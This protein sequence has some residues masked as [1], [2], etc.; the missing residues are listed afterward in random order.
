MK[1][2]TR[3]VLPFLLALALCACGQ[4]AT[5]W[6]EQYD[7]GVRYLSDGNYEGAILAFTAAIEIDPKRPETYI[8]RGAAYIGRG[9]TAEN[10][11]AAQADY[12]KAIELD[13]TN[14]TAY[15]SLA[16]V[17]IRLGE[18]D[19]AIELLREVLDRTGDDTEITDK[20][21]ELEAG[22]AT[23]SY[24]HIRRSSHYNEDV[25]IGYFV[26][27]YDAQG[28]KKTITA[29]DAAGNRLDYGEYTNGER[30]GNVE[31]WTYYSEGFAE[32]RVFLCRDEI[33]ITYSA[34]GSSKELWITYEGNTEINCFGKYN[35]TQG[36]CIKEEFYD[37]DGSTYMYILHTCDEA[38]N[39]IRSDCYSYDVFT[40][41]TT[42]E[43]DDNG[44][45]IKY[46]NFNA[47]GTLTSYGLTEYDANG[48]YIG[49]SYYEVDGAMQHSSVY[50]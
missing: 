8:G 6:Q 3:V 30:D 27:T 38:G 15:L 26:Y 2:I 41:Y 19:K 45:E 10:L 40:G 18:Y 31:R 33:E 32:N 35:D 17:Y 39:A 37:P 4:K 50:S 23:D 1:R 11:A 46:S 7:L 9:E 21:A 12:E 14:V 16:D 44:N 22:K 5:T 42:H 25:L 20:L 29:Y 43:Y 48:N 49:D 34:D 13:N 36:R 24:G 28:E 47:D